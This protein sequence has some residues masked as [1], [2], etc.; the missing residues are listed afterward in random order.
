MTTAKGG[1]PFGVR[2]R[3]VCAAVEQGARNSLEIAADINLPS[4]EA[5]RYARRAERHGMLTVDRSTL[6][7]T[8]TVI[9]GW[10]HL[11]DDWNRPVVIVAVRPRRERQPRAEPPPPVNSVFQMGDRAMSLVETHR[12]WIG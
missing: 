10:K 9:P 12:R 6:P 2:I 8:Y 1:R 11:L 7:H 5:C 3:Q 4:K